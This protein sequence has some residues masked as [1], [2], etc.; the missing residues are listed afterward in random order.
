[1]NPGISVRLSTR[2]IK[3]VADTYW[4]VYCKGCL[5]WLW[6]LARQIQ[7]LQAGPVGRAGWNSQAC[8]DT[9]VHR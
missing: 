1:L 9:A 6:R 5:L 8:T 4:E 2:E 7:K 3:P